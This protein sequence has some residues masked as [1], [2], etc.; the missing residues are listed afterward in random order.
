MNS[1]KYIVL[2]IFS[3]CIFCCSSKT[4]YQTLVEQELASGIRQDTFL[5]GFHFGM[6]EMKF[7]SECWDYNQKG[8]IKEGLG[9]RT[10]YYKLPGLKH[11]G[12]F[13]FFPIFKNGKIQSFKGFTAYDAWAPW[14]KHLWSEHLIEDTKELLELS[15][16]GNE[17]FATN[18][19]VEGKAYVKIDGNRRIVLYYKEE[20]RVEVLVSDLTNMDNELRLKQN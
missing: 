14:N 8:L 9:D 17:F 3:L 7:Y 12:Y 11:K 18:S 2:L 15:Y 6:P 5:L 19:P 1:I 20:S 13:D 16:P 4:K 10:V